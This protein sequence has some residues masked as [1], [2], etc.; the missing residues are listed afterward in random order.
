MTTQEAYDMGKKELRQEYIKDIMETEHQF[1]EDYNIPKT[2]LNGRAL[3][4]G[5]KFDFS[6][7]WL[8][9]I[10]LDYVLM[11]KSSGY[12]ST[13]INCA[14]GKEVRDSTMINC[15]N[16]IVENMFDDY[17]YDDFCCKYWSKK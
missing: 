14:Y 5:M 3:L 10:S 13:C 4:Q 6:G 9:K 12:E 1:I 16:E 2:F 11:Q 8:P 15:K 17:V 7:D